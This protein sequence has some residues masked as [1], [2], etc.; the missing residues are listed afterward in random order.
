[1]SEQNNSSKWKVFVGPIVTFVLILSGFIA[2]WA[3]MKNALAEIQKDQIKTE[4]IVEKL[5][6]KVH[7]IEIKSVFDGTTLQE[8]KVDVQEI[9]KDVKKLIERM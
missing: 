5:H 7:E 9:K 4:V 2:Q 8:L 3:T 6:S 1:M